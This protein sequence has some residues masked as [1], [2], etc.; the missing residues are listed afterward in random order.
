MEFREVAEHD[1]PALFEVRTA[2][3]ENAYTREQL[4]Q[5]GITPDSVSG[6]LAR[7]HRGW[8]CEVA[9]RVAGFAMG[10]QSTGELWVI[11]VRPE[12]EGRGIG[13]GLLRRVEAWLWSEGFEELWLTTDV[14]P[15]LRAYGFYR[16]HGWRDREATAGLRTMAKRRPRRCED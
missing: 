9:G 10:D 12:F 3:R 2:T 8:L 1:V 16:A 6:M 15:S 14:D 5:L 4:R 11:A 13:A 7:D